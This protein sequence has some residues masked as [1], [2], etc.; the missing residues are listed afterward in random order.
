MLFE[1]KAP[2]NI[3][4]CPSCQSTG[5]L[6]WRKCPVC[7]G[8]AMGHCRRGK[9]LYWSYPLTRYHLALEQGRRVLNRVRWFIVLFLGLIFWGGAGWQIYQSQLY[10]G[11]LFDLTSVWYFF[12]WL[13]V[14]CF[15]YLWYRSIRKKEFVGLVEPYEYKIQAAVEEENLECDNWG[16]VKKIPRRQRHNIVTAFTNEALMVLGQAY[17]TADKNKHELVNPFHLFYALLSSDRIGYIFLRLGISTRT[18]V[19]YLNPLF[20]SQEKAKISKNPPLVSPEIQ[21]AIFQAYEEAYLAHQ[22]YVS[23]T[24]LLITAVQQSPALQELLYDLNVNQQK[25]ANVVEWARIRERLYRQ[26]L[27]FR[28]AARRRPTSGLDKA[29][30]AVA[31]PYLNRFSQDLTLL[32]QFGHL[33]PCIAREKEIEEIFRVI[34]A[35]RQNVIL[36]GEP[37]VGRRSIIEGIA[38]KMIEEDVPDR[39]KD[40][41][42][43]QLSISSL[44]AGTTP[45]G[46]IDRLIRLMNEMARARN[47]ILFIHNL[48]ELM[49]VSAGG[50][51]GS[52]DVA[53]TLAEYL[54][55]GQFLTIATTTVQDFN[56]LII[57]S[58]IGNVFDKVE[59][60]EMNENQ[61]IQ[62]L[63]SKIGSVEHKNQIFFS[64]EALEKTVQLASRFVKDI[65][66]PGSALEI[67]G[68]AAAATRGKK[69][70]HSL[71]GAEEVARVVAEKTKIP[72]TSVTADESTKLLHL[73]EEMHKRIVGQEE[74]VDLVANA[75]RRAR[76]EIRSTKRPIANFLF[77]G[78]TG[79]GKT[80]LAKTI[81][82]VYFGGEKQMIRLDMSEYQDKASIY[83]LIG[84]L[85]EK[86]TGILTEAVRRQPFSLLLLDEIEKADPDILNLFLQVMDDGR[87]TDSTGRVIDF[88]NIIL[89]ATSNAGT[90]YVQEQ[91][92]AGLSP[93]AIKERLFH[94]ALKEYFRP[95]FLNRFDGIVLFRPLSQADLKKIVSLMLKR[96]AKDLEA[97]GVE[98]KVEEPALDFLVEIGFD[99]EY[100]ARPM[101]RALQDRIE[102]KLAELVIAGKL[103]RGQTV[104]LKQGG[105]M[106]IEG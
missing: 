81:A 68:E 22:E 20:T 71:V 98:L 99:P 18:L 5:F 19:D 66:L 63:E 55:Q 1:K 101:R 35:G 48:Q 72:V 91:M 77:L 9:W 97:K 79:V 25:L 23:V 96:T 93:E 17:Q 4:T 89:I 94:G 3:L 40:K 90:A 16:A 74:A 86:G 65:Y 29:M 50:Q 56:Q 41:R 47:I 73:E 100:G 83:R 85:G 52:L 62:V 70:R 58:T 30:T 27:K 33:H 92:R 24:E 10:R 59:I 2:L 103:K 61:A 12:F 69:G 60:K 6:A 37:G 51:R 95:E 36:V 28:H 32:A 44:L 105:E 45:A 102:N 76:A 106:E 49:G 8:M 46:A 88:T 38:Q 15:S 64:Y 84:A 87:L 75:L 82:D 54:S 34:E 31:T 43:V 53:G 26:Y 67:M 11:F 14:I 7:G 42:L 13:G 39:L 78:P 57:N 21:Q 104:V 80:E